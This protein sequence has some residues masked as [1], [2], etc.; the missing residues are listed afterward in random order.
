M[1]EFIKRVSERLSDQSSRRGFFAKVGKAVLG[2]ASIAAGG[3]LFTQVAEAMPK[4]CTLG[5][6][7]YGVCPSPTGP[8]PSGT[9][10]SYTWRCHTSTGVHYTCHDC[11]NSLNQLYCVYATRS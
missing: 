10:V 8:C 3:G 2:A 6:A 7:I 1:D 4:C 11:Y 5:H 9:H